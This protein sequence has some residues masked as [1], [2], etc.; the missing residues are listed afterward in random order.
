M[1]DLP[2]AA[3]RIAKAA[4]INSGNG[5]LTTDSSQALASLVLHRLVGVR[6]GEGRAEG[7]QRKQKAGRYKL[8]SARK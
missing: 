6:E 7:K 8:S 1:R 2:D 3:M 4:G 5:R